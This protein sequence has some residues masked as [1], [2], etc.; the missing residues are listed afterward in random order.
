MLFKSPLPLRRYERG[1]LNNIMKPRRISRT[2]GRFDL[3]VS[4][5][6]RIA[7]FLL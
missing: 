5:Y 6:S 3:T 2:F 7:R 1:C 4:L